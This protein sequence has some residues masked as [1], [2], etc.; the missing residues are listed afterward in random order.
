MMGI[1]RKFPDPRSEFLR[2][3]L[4]GLGDLLLKIWSPPPPGIGPEHLP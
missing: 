2:I 3:G 4:V 1:D